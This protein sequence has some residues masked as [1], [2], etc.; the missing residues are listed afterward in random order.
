MR[1]T[2]SASSAST[3]IAD[4][5]LYGWKMVWLNGETNTDAGKSD[6]RKEAA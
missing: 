4:S 1:Q 5:Q 3:A 2:A 6:T